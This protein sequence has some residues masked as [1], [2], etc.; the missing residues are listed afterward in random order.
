MTQFIS[1]GV[2]TIEKDLSAYISDLSSTIVGMVGTSEKGPT[3]TP[4]LITSQ[5]E[6]TDIF[7]SLSTKHYLGYAALAYLK[8]GNLL[9]VNR[10]C[11]SDATKAIAAFMLP[12]SYDRFEGNWTLTGQST[13]D[14]TLELS[15]Y[16][17]ATGANKVIKLDT[18]TVIPGFNPT[19]NTQLE[20][21]NDLIGADFNSFV[22]DKTLA[23]GNYAT[24]TLGA[25]KGVSTVVKDVVAGVNG[26]AIKLPLSSFSI[27]NS[28]AS[29]F[30]VGSISISQ[31]VSWT[32]PAV[33]TPLMVLGTSNDAIDIELTYFPTGFATDELKAT[34]RTNLTSAVEATR[35][36]ALETLVIA[37]AATKYEIG[38]PL[39]DPKVTGNNAKNLALIKAIFDVLLQVMAKTAA[40]LVGTYPNLNVAYAHIRAEVATNLFGVGYIDTVTGASKGFKGVLPI[41]DATG[42]IIS[43]Q[44]ESMVA[45]VLGIFKYSAQ[46]P[47]PVTPFVVQDQVVSGSFETGIYRPIWKMVQAGVASYVPTIVKVLSIGESDASN[48]VV[49]I[50]LD[51]D[52]LTSA[53]VQ[54][55]TFSVFERLTSVT[56]NAASLREQDFTLVE[57]YNG[58]LDN[59]QSNIAQNSRRISVKIDYT[60]ADS[61]DMETGLVTPSP[62]AP[63]G[64][65]FSPALIGSRNDSIVTGGY[66]YATNVSG[67]DK[68]FNTALVGG[69][70]GSPI[71]KYDIIGDASA[72][73]GVYAFANPEIM[74]INVLVAPGW[75]ADPAIAKTMVSLCEDRGDAIAILDTPF[76]LS[77]QN[78]VN[79]RKNISNINSSYAAMYYP[80]VKITDA[81]NNKDIFV[82]PSGQVVAQY[83]Y[84]DQ[85]S[86][87]FYAPAGRT[88]GSLTDVLTTER[89]LNQG[90][91]DMLAL[92][93]INPIHNEASYGIYIK[94][95]YTLQTN[96][97]ALDRVNVRRLL[98][99]LRKL[100][101]TASKAF[102]FEPGDTVTAYRL[103]QVAETL[104]EDH[105]KR[106]AISAYKVDVGPNV[107]TLL[108]RENNELRMEISIIPTKTA[109]KIIE[110]FNILPQGGGVQLA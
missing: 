24:I 3:N 82:P 9:W 88:R 77:V 84:N 20:S 26:P 47:T 28:P 80:W 40:P 21:A 29:A 1:A 73:T 91:R 62:I 57:Q 7:G 19:D 71:T 11:P 6:Y 74:D 67:Y 37:T 38:V 59:I 2:Y 44:L 106:G 16:V 107:N 109:E 27:T 95:Q 61:L 97:T 99:K 104:L 92:N 72:N 51:V 42:A 76:G 93:H 64:L 35:F 56:V 39:Y 78:V 103:K 30:P 85:V 81:V 108:T 90:D 58:T 36:A 45:G 100:V 12:E 68:S 23:V 65:V 31:P 34:L 79:Y 49:T 14:I 105:Y 96:T 110:T 66:T 69:S 41:Y 10:V 102:E 15:D 53:K 22:A 89:V 55:Y 83:A 25:G 48:T 13:S 75:S 63:D 98:L 94:G 17:T 87:V 8:K 50:G 5:K 18:A 33:S 46:T 43:I 32:A 54:N 4:I 101:A 86:D 70:V 52:N 60:T